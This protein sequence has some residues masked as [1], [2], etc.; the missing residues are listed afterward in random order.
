MEKLTEYA[1][2]DSE[3]YGSVKYK[4]RHFTK[5]KILLVITTILAVLALTFIILFAVEKSKVHDSASKPV[6][7][8]R[9][10]TYCGTETCFYTALGKPSKYDFILFFFF[11]E[12]RLVLLVN[13]YI[14]NTYW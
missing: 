1:E 14:S 10:Q 3:D 4:L 13:Q 2:Y 7:T 9:V 6:K 11:F 12:L 8:P 5:F